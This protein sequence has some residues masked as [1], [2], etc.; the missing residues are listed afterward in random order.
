MLFAVIRH[1]DARSAPPAVS[2]S[3]LRRLSP[4]AYSAVMSMPL[5]LAGFSAGVASDP[6]SAAAA[7]DLWAAV[8]ATGLPL[9]AGDDPLFVSAFSVGF[10]IDIREPVAMGQ[11][12]EGRR[13]LF[14]CFK[15]F[16]RVT[17]MG[18]QR[19]EGGLEF[20]LA[21]GARY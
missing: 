15:C 20:V 17:F 4:A 19:E 5:I 3:L 14:R 7:G 1:T 21:P 9:A 16:V 10:Q 12:F 2:K 13:C 6:P 18:T 8:A 11:I